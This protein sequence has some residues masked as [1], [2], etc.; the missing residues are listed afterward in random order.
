MQKITVKSIFS[1]LLKLTCIILFVAT[2]TQILGSNNSLTWVGILIGIMMYWCMDLGIDKKQAP[3]LIASLYILTGICNR[4]AL[5]HPILGFI[6]NFVT[7]Q[8]SN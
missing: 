5:I 6:I 7:I 4:L 8:S 2:F 3:F 1:N